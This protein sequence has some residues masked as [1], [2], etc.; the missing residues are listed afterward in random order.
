MA[1]TAKLA[2]SPVTTETSAGCVLMNGVDG[3]LCT[4][5]SQAASRKA[6]AIST[7]VQCHPFFCAIIGFT[8]L[9]PCSVARTA[10]EKNASGSSA[11]SHD[12]DAKHV[13]FFRED[14]AADSHRWHDSCKMTFVTGR[15]RMTT[16]N[17][18]GKNAVDTFVKPT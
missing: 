5:L 10:L 7:N 4:P 3:G 6:V 1:T 13:R 11:E 12:V 16:P 8:S 9:F 15:I 18:H 14:V 17:I 2:G